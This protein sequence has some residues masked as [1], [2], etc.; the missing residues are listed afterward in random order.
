MNPFYLS[1]KA[2]LQLGLESA[3]VTANDHNLRLATS[4]LDLHWD[5][6]L[7][8]QLKPGQIWQSMIYLIEK[9]HCDRKKAT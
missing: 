7:F 2:N 5:M 3:F 1:Q 9:Y 6:A 4:F 8:S